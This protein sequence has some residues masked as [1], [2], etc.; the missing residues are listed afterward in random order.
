M[1]IPA[2]D[3]LL[4]FVK[5]A[6]C[7]DRRIMEASSKFGD[8]TAGGSHFPWFWSSGRRI[9]NSTYFAMDSKPTTLA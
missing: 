5:K 9:S 8:D 1:C 4:H 6:A 2:R 7:S 3:H